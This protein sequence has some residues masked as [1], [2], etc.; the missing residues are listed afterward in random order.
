VTSEDE[1]Q[2]LLEGVEFVTRRGRSYLDRYELV[3][4]SGEW[5]RAGAVPGGR[6]A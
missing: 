5:R 2:G 3:D 4:E 1:F 6:S